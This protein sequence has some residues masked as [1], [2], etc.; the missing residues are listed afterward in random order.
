LWV[1]FQVFQPAENCFSVFTW[2]LEAL[3]YPDIEIQDAEQDPAELLEMVQMV[4]LYAVG[5]DVIFGEGE[6]FGFDEEQAFPVR[7][8][9]S[10]VTPEKDV[11][12][13]EIVP[14]PP[15]LVPMPKR[16]K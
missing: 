2:A 1:D 14:A 15:G 7:Y 3:G 11:L 5:N 4:A 9:P 10:A 12:V 6:T 13:L 16:R 8:G